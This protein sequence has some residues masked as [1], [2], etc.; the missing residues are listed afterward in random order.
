MK[1]NYEKLGNLI[2]I[3]EK[4]N[5]DLAVENLVG[6]NINKE[7]MPS[8]ANTIG[9]N[10]SRYKVI[11]KNQFACNL[12]HVGRDK[13]VV[14]SKYTFEE[15]SII[16]PAYKIFQVKDESII[17]PDFLMLYFLRS[18]FDRLGW[19]YTDN[20][21]R[22]SLDWSKFCNIEIPVPDIEIQ[23]KIVD[24]YQFF[25]DRIKIKENIND[26]L[27]NVLMNEFLQ[28]FVYFEKYSGDFKDSDLGHIPKNWHIF[29][30]ENLVEVIDN[31][32]K[33]PPL[34]NNISDYPIIDVKPLS[35]ETRIINYDNCTKFVDK[36]TYEN[37]FRSGHP[38][39]YDILISTVGSIAELK[40]F[41]GSKGCI[42]QNVVALRPK[43][44]YS[45][46][47]YQYLL[48]IKKELENYDRGSVQPSIK[49]SQFIK[50]KILIPEDIYVKKFNNMS[51]C[52][53]RKIYL[54]NLEINNLKKI[55]G[56]LIFSL[57]KE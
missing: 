41:F 15:P 30:L 27:E 3:S 56:K 54:N 9:T 46:Y 24:T 7:F 47:L 57:L 6:M 20:S 45:L 53:T 8:V 29:P 25:D 11:Q 16:S 22:G 23:K 2:E 4:K 34:V 12:M 28:N 51:E 13:S 36:E 37:W 17:L 33:T 35:D 42:A 21:I 18:E 19:F 49:V 26:N 5:S 10:L 43:P 48:F 31:R 44:F 39:E 1:F 50:H 38:K 40:L 14:V 32:G 55:R 52:F